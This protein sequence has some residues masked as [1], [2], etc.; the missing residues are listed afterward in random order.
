LEAHHYPFAPQV[1]GLDERAR[2]VLSYV[3]GTAMMRP[4]P[5]PLRELD[6]LDQVG[7]ALRLLSHASAS[8]V[9]TPDA[10]W[11]APAL[12]R[13]GPVRHGDVGPWNAIFHEGRL[14]GF[15][16]WE[17]AE[18]APSLWDLA[19]AAWYF[20]PLR[21]A[22]LGWRAAGFSSEPDLA[23][24]LMR[25]CKAFGEPAPEVVRELSELQ[26]V[27]LDRTQSLGGDGVMPW[28]LFLERGDAVELRQEIE[29]LQAHRRSLIGSG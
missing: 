21:P 18:P 20:V 23:E 29:W 19:Q 14:A 7:R 22:E 15:I 9:P 3:H 24:R 26:Q 6:V 28:R 27:E 12:K 11:Q 13:S 25:L 10:R 4:W 8:F 1:L 2:E 17:F 5:E 16:D